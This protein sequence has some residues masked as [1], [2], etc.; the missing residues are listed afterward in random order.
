MGVF[1]SLRSD[2]CVLDLYKSSSPTIPYVFAL[3]TQG[4]G[5]DVTMGVE[6]RTLLIS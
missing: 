4:L 1:F 5:M 2:D 3:S 6:Y